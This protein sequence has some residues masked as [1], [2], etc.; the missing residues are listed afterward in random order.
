VFNDVLAGCRDG[1]QGG[2]ALELVQAMKSRRLTGDSVTHHRVVACLVRSDR[3]AEALDYLR[4]LEAGQRR[5]II[6][7][8][9]DQALRACGQLGDI[10]TAQTLVQEM[11]EQVRIIPFHAARAKVLTSC[12]RHA[13]TEARL[14][15]HCI[16]HDD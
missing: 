8:C 16:R 7:P 3:Y 4:N 9:Y 10:T 13:P 11:T 12:S 5:H 15:C 1:R 14:T 6:K 2:L